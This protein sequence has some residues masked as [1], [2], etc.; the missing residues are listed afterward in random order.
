[1]GIEFVAYCRISQDKAGAGL[2]VERQE[3]D[4]RDWA[5]ANGHTIAEV[6]TDNDISAYSGKPRPGFEKLLQ[7]SNKNVVVW[8]QDRLL[9]V[10]TDLQKVI[11]AE[12]TVYQVTAGKL[13]LQTPTGKMQARVTATMA[14]YEVEQK[15]ERQLA[16]NRQLAKQGT[17]RGSIRP[18]GNNRDG[19]QVPVEAQ[20]VKDA[21]K[22]MLATDESH[23]TFYGISK[24]WNDAGLKTPQTGK[25]GGKSWTAGTVRQYFTRPRLYGYQ[26]YKGTLYP[27]AD[28]E[29]L[30]TKDEFDAVQVYIQSNSAKNRG[31]VRSPI[32][33]DIHLLTGILKCTEPVK[34]KATRQTYTCNRG[35]N[36]AYRGGKYNTK[37]YK[38]PTTGHTSI[39]AKSSE[40]Y[41]SQHALQLLSQDAELHKA[42]KRT[43][44]DGI[45]LRKERAELVTKQEE[46]LAEAIEASLSPKLIAQR[47]AQHTTDLSRIDAQL[48]TL[49]KDMML[50]IF[51]TGGSTATPTASARRDWPVTPAKHVVVA[52]AGQVLNPF[53]GE[54]EDRTV[55]QEDVTDQKAKSFSVPVPEELTGWNAADVSARRKLLQALFSNI[56]VSRRPQGSRAD[57]SEF[58][59]FEYTELGERLYRAWF[60]SNNLTPFMDD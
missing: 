60:E 50:S 31:G 54:M 11:D 58:I 6:I 12:L 34:D 1:M 35:M 39:V 3:E 44:A 26:D 25:Q 20:A 30:L 4:I 27:L 57:V 38:C 42:N 32:R 52:G 17:Y 53:T 9:R 23:M 18:F 43:K 56:A 47:E 19:S 37:A 15:T 24:L 41:I 49:D 22:S 10:L 55:L 13:D 51:V 28:W 21:V 59:S 14:T 40:Y 5:T 45:K 16:K 8:H 33:H 7:H 46:W 36:V 2:A 29:P 48:A